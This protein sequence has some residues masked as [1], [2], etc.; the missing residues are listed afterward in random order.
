M[1]ESLQ[2]ENPCPKCGKN[3]KP[4]LKFCNYCGINLGQYKMNCPS[5]GKSI[6]KGLKFCNYCGINLVQQ[7]I[8]KI[9]ITESKKGIEVHQ[10][11][12]VIGGFVLL[13][14]AFFHLLFMYLDPMGGFW[15]YWILGDPEQ[16]I[17]LEV[18]FAVILGIF[19]AIFLSIVHAVLYFIMGGFLLSFKKN[20]IV[21]SLT[22]V[23]S[24]LGIGLGLRA[25][26]LYG[27]IS[28]FLEF[29]II[30]DI[31]VLA[32]SIYTIIAPPV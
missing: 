27:Y 4:G 5:C 30:I 25:I 7:K 31:V 21:P 11:V 32:I 2:L 3:I 12:R 19:I 23:F 14:S 26:F 22:I 8:D 15:Y 16:Y 24:L 18:L 9:E 13:F 1:S 6:K 29:L 20:R 28:E 10:I 17:G